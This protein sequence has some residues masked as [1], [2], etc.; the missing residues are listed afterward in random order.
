M[1]EYKRFDR[2]TLM[3][4]LSFVGGLVL[5]VLLNLK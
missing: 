2:K 3:I 1:S 5:L 4:M